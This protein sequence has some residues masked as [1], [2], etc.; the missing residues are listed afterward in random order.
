M[1]G[2]LYS[3]K[4]ALALTNILVFLGGLRKKSLTN[5]PAPGPRAR[6]AE[7][8]AEADREPG[9]GGRGPGRV[10]SRL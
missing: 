2:T 5:G 4:T 8:C 7:A 10:V 9:R 1:E 6:G 3:T